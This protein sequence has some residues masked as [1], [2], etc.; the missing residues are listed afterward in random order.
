MGLSFS[1]AV[2][3]DRPEEPFVVEGAYAGAY[4]K[5]VSDC[6][7]K[8][9]DGSGFSGGFSGG[10]D[11]ISDYVNSAQA[12]AK[13][14]IA[15]SILQA[16][17]QLGF[18]PTGDSPAE[19]VKNLIAMIPT[20]DK[21]KNDPTVHKKTCDNIARAINS[22]Y[23][24]QVINIE[25]STEIV[26]QQVVE[27]M[28]SLISGMHTEFLQV[29]NDV[30]KVLENLQVLEDFMYKN[31]SQMKEKISTSED[32]V[33]SRTLQ[34][35]YDLY[36]TIAGE[37]KRQIGILRNLLNVQLAPSVKDLASMLK[38]KQDISGWIKKISPKAGRTNMGSVISDML[39]GMGLTADFALVVNK[40]LSEIGVT[41][42]EY[43][44]TKN[45]K[46]LAILALERT[47]SMNADE[48][49]KFNIALE[50]L[51]KH[52]HRKEDIANLSKTGSMDTPFGADAA[53]AYNTSTEG[54][55]D[56]DG[57]GGGVGDG[58][59]GGAEYQHSKMDKRIIDR[60]KLRDL[61]FTAFNRE[62]NSIIERLVAALEVLGSKV[63]TEIPVSDQLDGF[64]QA[65]TRVKTSIDLTRNK[66]IYYALIGYYNDAQSKSKRDQVVGELRM[67]SSFIETIIQMPMYASSVGYFQNVHAQIKSFMDLIGKYSEE[68]SVKFGRGESSDRSAHTRSSTH[69]AGSAVLD[70]TDSNVFNGGSHTHTLDIPD[71]SFP[72][73]SPITGNIGLNTASGSV[74]GEAAF[75]PNYGGGNAIADAM[76]GGAG[77]VGD[78]AYDA[79]GVSY[80]PFRSGKSLD[81]AITK[82]DYMYNVSK[83][84]TNLQHAG[85]ELSH[86]GEKYEKLV[87]NSIADILRDDQVIYQNN[88]KELQKA[89]DDDAN[90]VERGAALE[91]LN[92]QWDAKKKFWA[93]IEAVDMY[94]KAFTDGF[95]NNPSDIKEI[96]SA[97]DD[98]EI[99]RDWYSEKSGNILVDVF[100]KFPASVPTGTTGAATGIDSSDYYATLQNDKVAPGVPYNVTSAKDGK[101]AR[102]G[103][104]KM[105]QSMSALKNLMS[106]F[107]HF[108]AKFGGEEIRKKVFMTP[109]Q[110]Y[111]NLVEYLQAS[112][113]AQGYQNTMFET[114]DKIPDSY[115]ND[116]GAVK[117]HARAAV[118]KDVG[119]TVTKADESSG[120]ADDNEAAKKANGKVLFRKNWGVHMRGIKKEIRDVG[121]NGLNFNREDDY[122]VLMLKS[123]GAKILTVTGMYDVFDRPYEKNLVGNPI[124]MIMGGNSEV[125][126]VD[127]GAIALYLR[128]PLLC[129]FWREIFGFDKGTEGAYDYEDYPSM[130]TNKTILKISMVPDVDGMFA[131]LIRL[132]FR[133]NKF[134]NTSTFT[135]EDLKDIIRECNLIYQRMLSKHPQNT[136]MET[137]YELVNEINRRYGIV[138][139]HDRDK[140]NSEFGYD[141]SYGTAGVVDRYDGETDFEIPLLPGETDEEIQRPS[142]AERLLGAGFDSNASALKSKYGIVP[143]HRDIVWKFRCAIDKYFENPDESYSF[144]RAI[145]SVKQK[146]KRETRDEERFKIVSGLIRGIDIYSQ[147][148]GLKYVMFHESVITGLNALSGVHTLLQR[149]QSRVELID[150]RWHIR[151]FSKWVEAAAA[152]PAPAPAVDYDSLIDFAAAKLKEVKAHHGSDDEVKKYLKRLYCKEID[153]NDFSG[154]IDS[155]NSITMDGTT[156]KSAAGLAKLLEGKTASEIEKYPR[157]CDNGDVDEKIQTFFRYF[158]NHDFAMTELVESVYGIS[159]DLQGLIK[160]KIDEGKLFLNTGNLTAHVKKAIEQVTRF[161]EALRPHVHADVVANYT[162]KLNVGSLYWLQEN[163]IEKIIVGRPGEEFESNLPYHNLE[164]LARKL[165]STY[166]MLTS[167]FSSGKSKFTDN[168]DVSVD[169]INS[170]HSYGKVFSEM[171]FYDGTKINS[172]LHGSVKTLANAAPKIVDY[173]SND[174]DKL[175]LSGVPGTSGA[176]QQTLDTRFCARFYQLY[177]WDNEFTY[178]RSALFAF[179]QLIA[180][181]IQSFYDVSEKKIYMG[182]I[183]KFANGTFSRSLADFKYTF[184][185]MA[186]CVGVKSTGAGNLNAPPVFPIDSNLRDKMDPMVK[187]L[188]EKFSDA[189]NIT[190]QFDIKNN[191]TKFNEKLTGDSNYVVLVDAPTYNNPMSA[192]RHAIRLFPYKDFRSTSSTEVENRVRMFVQLWAAIASKPRNERSALKPSDMSLG[193]A[194]V[195][196]PGKQS[197]TNT[198]VTYES[199]TSKT[200]TSL[201]A[202]KDIPSPPAEEVLILLARSAGVDGY[203]PVD[204]FKTL[205]ADGGTMDLAEVLNFGQRMDPDGDHVLFTS[206]AVVLKNLTTTRKD[207]SNFYVTSSVQELPLYM[208]EKMRANLPAFKNLFRELVSRCELLKQFSNRR[209][210]D[211]DR[212]SDY[213]DV[214][215][216]PWPFVLQDPKTSSD[217][218]KNRFTGILDTII[219]GCQTLIQSSEQ[220]LKEV[221]DDPKYL[222]VYQNSIRDYKASNGF[223]PLMPVSTMLEVTAEQGKSELRFFPVHNLGEADFK[224]MYGMRGLLDGQK[225]T[226]ESV[227]GWANLVGDFNLMMDSR[228]QVDDSLSGDFLSTLVSSV[229]FIHDLRRVKAMLTPYVSI[230]EDKVSAKVNANANAEDKLI[231]GAFTRGNMYVTNSDDVGL[232][233]NK[234]DRS[235]V[236]IGLDEYGKKTSESAIKPAFIIHQG[237]SKGLSLTDSS[238]KTDKLRELVDYVYNSSGK[239]N[240]S[241]AVQNIIDLN[242]VP[243]NVHALMREIPLANLYNYA[244]TFDRLVMNMFLGSDNKELHEKLCKGECNAKP[245]S[246]IE[247]NSAREM[248]VALLLDPYLDLDTVK[249]GQSRS[250]KSLYEYVTEVMLGGVSGESIGRPKFLSDQMYGKALLMSTYASK[251]GVN[252]LGPASDPTRYMM[253]KD[254]FEVY[255]EVMRTILVDHFGKGKRYNR[256]ELK[257]GMTI[258][259]LASNLARFM[260]D[261][262]RASL[263]EINQFVG[264]FVSNNDN[265]QVAL[266]AFVCGFSCAG[267]INTFDIKMVN[268]DLKDY[269][270]AVKNGQVSQTTELKQFINPTDSFKVSDINESEDVEELDISDLS[271]RW[272]K[273]SYPNGD[274]DLH[275]NHEKKEVLVDIGG[276]KYEV[277]GAAA[278]VAHMRFDTVLSRNLVFVLNLYRAVRIKLHSDLVYDKD[279]IT[280]SI[281]ITRAAVT[282]FAGND[283]YDKDGKSSR[284]ALLQ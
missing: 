34:T 238:S 4:E 164:Q 259:N 107:V 268:E 176:G 271:K 278:D 77:A 168:D 113:L 44:N 22:A 213:K 281:P 192:L 64:R 128:L 152:A 118:T 91:F 106:V 158:F 11:T 279:I 9:G 231:S 101:D 33:L 88:L 226:K 123:I 151:C 248:L 41:L 3:V 35:N 178:N 82:F 38:R 183:D 211:L 179:N 140:Y 252:E 131:G 147:I 7:C 10:A 13:K 143:D 246:E 234:Y 153:N 193:S 89:T 154:K 78:I 245:T 76:F 214:T 117:Y 241:L 163:L 124:R 137:I 224:V 62:L 24:A 187:K 198:V 112:A 8:H 200:N 254:A 172:G 53:M 127:E 191:L 58:V 61:V 266:V 99:I 74:I 222:E 221:G 205:G 71:V 48:L 253:R 150:L 39:S 197:Q 119:L 202:K 27:V 149:F 98:I 126:K 236:K 68:I 283:K 157:K 182:L 95:V 57:F 135:D 145:M 67:I 185:D 251:V 86:Y 100:E 72:N 115:A 66:E 138:S 69:G 144:S 195:Y 2:G 114:V 262:Q 56:G 17:S 51:S 156:I 79:G 60:K 26:C 218:S 42:A 43:R 175:F 105:F 230:A 110:I 28:S 184:P 21:F 204:S 166:G 133:K 29:F 84:R 228:M 65:L 219:R 194:S 18:K 173:L 274:D 130:K 190:D 239:K 267:L 180:K 265:G 80:A 207:T 129:E 31:M 275:H 52:L 148:D 258:E 167:K 122:F 263:S 92:A 216:Q 73:T 242:I 174:Y 181:F 97:L 12:G 121:A 220:T 208:K 155:I 229:R 255:M 136:V 240:K 81:R 233:K 269:L 225:P 209:E 212:T 19:K 87:A 132:M 206:L 125:P 108:G 162:K 161:V 146:L 111:T 6:G 96:R 186:P 232:V 270:N 256:I 83:I 188:V 94:M 139:Q 54:S 109:A 40:A 102:D 50:F 75:N 177:T 264:K 235:I 276:N 30:K 273:K 134:M 227:P 47:K 32:P 284:K 243:I 85:K 280:R 282:E 237:Y 5:V 1:N 14:H 103:I 20:G 223:D 116:A 15:E 247:V 170:T 93:T 249:D 217:E 16:A 261:N 63:G 201:Y 46:D 49:H 171:V 215:Q 169:S 244:Y 36:K 142:A 250:S 199:L 277:N 210:V 23:G 257:S 159:N 196:T 189:E 90:S 37:S 104:K 25:F 141:Y 59:G 70:A 165:T 272:K 203:L 160:F 260:M 120:T 55:L 45:P